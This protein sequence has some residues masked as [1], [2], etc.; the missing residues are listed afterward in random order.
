[1]A[2]TAG[3]NA[4]IISLMVC[5]GFVVCW[6]P[7]Q[8]MFFLNFVGYAVDFGGWFYHLTVVLVFT[9]SCVNPFI[10]AAKYREFQH[11]VRRLE[12]CVARRSIQVQSLEDTTSVHQQSENVA[13]QP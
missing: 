13:A 12:S 3:R 10:Y 9:N 8:I 4:A 5:C 11:G 6:S 2:H 1:V 7:N